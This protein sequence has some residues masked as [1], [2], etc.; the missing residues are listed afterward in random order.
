[1]SGCLAAAGAGISAAATA[2]VGAYSKNQA[3][4]QN[5]ALYRS[6]MEAA[7]VIGKDR[8]P[9]VF[10]PMSVENDEFYC[11]FRREYATYAGLIKARGA[12]QAAEI[13]VDNAAARSRSGECDEAD[14]MLTSAN[15]LDLS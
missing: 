15:P 9:D 1:M 3:H 12:E 6:D 7:L 8:H 4:E 5:R 11:L 10:G 14:R 13:A 2:G